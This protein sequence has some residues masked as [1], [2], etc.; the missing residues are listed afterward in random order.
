MQTLKDFVTKH[1]HHA[2]LVTGDPASAE[3]VYVTFN[4][5]DAHELGRRASLA[6]NDGETQIFSIGAY[7]IGLEAQNALLK[8][9]EEPVLGT[10]FVIIT[11]YPDDL[12]PTLRSRLYIMSDEDLE[13]KLPLGS[14]ASKS[15]TFDAGKFL[16]KTPIERLKYLEKSFFDVRD[17]SAEVHART[18]YDA[19]AILTALELYYKVEVRLPESSRSLTSTFEILKQSKQYI[20]DTAPAVKLILESLALHLPMI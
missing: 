3:E 17:E 12:L 9:F 1:P 14:L 19:G 8:L 20:H 2:F 16:A 5:A 11:P 4:I 13:A 7:G 10:K 15:E 6:V 18:K